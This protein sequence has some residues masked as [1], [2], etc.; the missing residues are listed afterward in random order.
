M[1][2]PSSKSSKDWKTYFFVLKRDKELKKSVLDYYKDANKCKKQERKGFI[3][4]WPYFQ[5]SLAHNS[6]YQ[7]PLTIT[8]ANNKEYTIS[9][10]SFEVMNK[11]C[12]SLQMQS[13]LVPSTT[14]GRWSFP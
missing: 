7:Y 12:N 3:E 9:A 13:Y 1:K 14:K 2:D 5:V 8:D 4:L 10:T 6:S 11:W